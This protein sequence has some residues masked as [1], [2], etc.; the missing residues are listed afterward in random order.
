MIDCFDMVV[1]GPNG[2]VR[3]NIELDAKGDPPKCIRIGERVFVL[4]GQLLDGTGRRFRYFETIIVEL[5]TDEEL[6]ESRH[7][8]EMSGELRDA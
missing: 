5:L 2:L 3:R 7:L 8:R 4:S 1:E 6:E